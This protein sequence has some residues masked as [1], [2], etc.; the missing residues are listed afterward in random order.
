[1]HNGDFF[2]IILMM[3]IVLPSFQAYWLRYSVF[4]S[5]LTLK[6]PSS[7]KA[8]YPSEEQP[9]PVCFKYYVVRIKFFIFESLG[10]PLELL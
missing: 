3:M 2:L 1:M 8:P 5:E 4:P 9:G 7:S 10:K 6:G